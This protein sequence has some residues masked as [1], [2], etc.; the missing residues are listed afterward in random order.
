MISNTCR[1]KSRAQ[2]GR[3]Y[4]YARRAFSS[5]RLLANTASSETHCIPSTGSVSSGINKQPTSWYFLS[6][7]LNT[8]LCLRHRTNYKAH[9]RN[10]PGPALNPTVAAGQPVGHLVLVHY[11]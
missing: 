8:Q 9:S 3:A 7:C 4:I 10:K 11:W 1:E 2:H 6:L 5:C